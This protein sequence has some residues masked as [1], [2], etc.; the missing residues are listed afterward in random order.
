MIIKKV[1]CIYY[2]ATR[3][4]QKI[5]HKIAEGTGLKIEAPIDLTNPK[6]REKFDGKL[7]SDL[8][9]VGSPVYEGTIPSILLETLNK[10]E[11]N[12][13][14]AIPVGVYGTRS[15][16][17]YVAE[18]SGF[19]RKRGFK[20]LAGSDFVAEHSYAH[21]EAP[22]G[23][24]RPDESDLK[25]AYLFGNRIAQIIDNPKEANIESKSLKFGEN[26]WLD[27]T[28]WPENRIKARISA[29][30][31]DITKCIK[32][33][34]CLEVCPVEAINPLS[35]I[36]DNEKCIRCMAC[37][38][39]CPTNAK[40]ITYPSTVSTFINKWGKMRKEPTLYF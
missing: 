37:I 35:Y 12:N 8:V 27:K 34:K 22:A 7:D 5:I 36:S 16:E 19:L 28:K 40:T 26:Y 33:N 23:I 11:G 21:T 17:K 13:K 31:Y 39:K 29:P 25:I 18:L 32:C 38:K 1:Q 14:W 20:I 3:T 10:L 4:T 24:G 30:N 9:L 15:A 2:S 6:I